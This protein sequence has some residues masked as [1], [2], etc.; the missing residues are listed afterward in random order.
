MAPSIDP[1]QA[2]IQELQQQRDLQWAA[3]CQTAETHLDEFRPDRLVRHA[4]DSINGQFDVQSDL[5][6]AG[7]HLAAAS[8]TR[9]ILGKSKNKPLKKWLNVILIYALSAVVIRYKD[10]IIEA[11][12][13]L[14]DKAK[15][16][17]QPE[18][19]SPE[20]EM[21]PDQDIFGEEGV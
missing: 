11:G 4:I 12:A 13:Q 5:L 19:N 2:R 9:G 6:Q 10:Q 8:M 14:I 1:I 18:T 7:V 20:G 17:L 21:M 16:L 3:L 15:D